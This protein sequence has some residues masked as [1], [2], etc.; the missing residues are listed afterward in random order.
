[1]LPTRITTL[2]TIPTIIPID[3][4]ESVSLSVLYAKSFGYTLKEKSTRT[5][6]PAGGI[7]DVILNITLKV[8]WVV[9]LS[10]SVV[11]WQ[12]YVSSS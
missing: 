7:P 1:M 4:I 6:L 9:Q 3:F 5:G 2:M 8:L 12:L 11:K 10:T